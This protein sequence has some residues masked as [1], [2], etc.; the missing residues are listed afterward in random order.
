MKFSD[1]Q[2][3][4]DQHFS[5]FPVEFPDV[6]VV[7]RN[8]IRLSDEERKELT[9]ISDIDPE[10]VDEEDLN[11]ILGRVVKQAHD[12]FRIVADT[13]EGGELLVERVGEDAA[14]CLEILQH[15]R[16]EQAVGEA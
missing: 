11:D 1:I 4:A 10:K 6:T 7:L 13:P 15:Y 12:T 2:K 5:G 16:E 8:P 14:M 9:E 3:G